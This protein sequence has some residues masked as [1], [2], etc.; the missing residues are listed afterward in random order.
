[1]LVVLTVPP[2]PVSKGPTTLEQLA[3]RQYFRNN[4]DLIDVCLRQKDPLEGALELLGALE[5]N[6]RES[7][8]VIR[9]EGRLPARRI[10]RNRSKTFRTLEIGCKAVLRKEEGIRTVLGIAGP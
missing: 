8:F 7:V 1:L 4:P 3:A 9:P 5:E 2:G 10:T 6:N